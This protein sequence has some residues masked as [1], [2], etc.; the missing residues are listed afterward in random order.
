MLPHSCSF[1]HLAVAYVPCHGV[2]LVQEG[3]DPN[4]ELNLQIRSIAARHLGLT[5]LERRFRS[6]LDGIAAPTVRDRVDAAL[7]DVLV[8]TG[9]GEHPM[10]AEPR[11]RALRS[12]REGRTMSPELLARQYV[13]AAMRLICVART[14]DDHLQVPS[15]GDVELAVRE[16]FSR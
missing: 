10:G 2:L 4:D 1:G 3:V 8:R 12:C 6:E 5:Q 15:F 11:R 7:I 14:A 9:H 16:Q 13:A